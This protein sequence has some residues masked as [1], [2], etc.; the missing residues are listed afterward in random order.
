MIFQFLRRPDSSE[1]VLFAS[2][3]CWLFEVDGRNSSKL[4]QLKALIHPDD[5]QAYEQSVAVSAATLQPW[6]WE[7]RIVLPSGR[8]K[9]LQCASRPEQQPNGD[10][11]WDGLLMDVT[12]RKQ[13]EQACEQQ[14]R[15]RERAIA[16]RSI[17]S[18]TQ[19]ITA[20]PVMLIGQWS[21]SAMKVRQ[22]PAI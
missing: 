6:I 13:V 7:G 22:F 21:L 1:S 17:V 2:S 11:L 5:R 19:V 3:G 15:Q 12:E 4:S 9:W 14:K 20:V 16:F 8:L 18:S 10:I